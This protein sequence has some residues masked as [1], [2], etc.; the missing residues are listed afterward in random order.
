MRK[1]IFLLLPL[2]LFSCKAKQQTEQEKFVQSRNEVLNRHRPLIHNNDGDD[3]VFSGFIPSEFSIQKFLNTRSSR[4]IGTDATTLSYC[5]NRSFSLHLHDTKVGECYTE[6]YYLP[7]RKNI[8]SEL[9]KMGTD[10]LEVTANFAHENGLE[11]FWSHRMN[12][13]HD[14]AHR[15]DNPHP[16]WNQF[17][18]EH[19]EYLFGAIAE[20]IPHGNW[21][22]VDYSHQEVRDLCVQYFTEVCE[23]YNVD[24]IEMDFFRHPQLFKNVGQGGIAT[25]EQLIMLTDMVNQIREMTQRVGQEKGKPIL[26]LARVPDSHEYCRRIGIDLEEWMEKGLIDIVVGGGYYRLNPWNYLVEEGKKHGVKVYADFSES[27]VNNEHPYLIRNQSAVYRARAAAAWQSGVDGIYSF[28][29]FN[30]GRQHFKEIGYPEKLKG[31]NNLYFVTYR[32]GNPNS[33]LN[34]GRAHLNMPMVSPDNQ[35]SLQDP[36]EFFVEIGDERNPARVFVILYTKNVNPENLEVS[37]NKNSAALKNST[38]D[39]LVIFEV[40]TNMVLQGE[41]EL[42]IKYNSSGGNPTLLDAA[43][44]FSRY[45]D[46]PALQSLIAVCTN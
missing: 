19:P 26:V 17:K 9:I 31:T 33:Y 1:I 38:N 8:V 32:N 28:N 29:D 18:E 35:N 34:N 4:I 5:T 27:R 12:D 22:A 24:G 16:Q 41:N 30:L 37:M 15:L 20:R 7:Q 36:L 13:T 14:A 39:G 11:F 25:Q 23:N 6:D 2:L 10:P 40:T 45:P 21:S 44:L 42:A 46:E 43:I 3:H